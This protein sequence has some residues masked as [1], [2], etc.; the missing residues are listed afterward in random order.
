M[1]MVN[2]R[3][4]S[5]RLVSVHFLAWGPL[6]FSL[7]LPITSRCQR[8]GESFQG[9]GPSLKT[10]SKID[11]TLGWVDY[12]LAYEFGFVTVLIGDD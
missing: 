12:E 11:G 4:Y 5:S 3:V 9:E 2:A 7:N 1:H 8:F 6:K 10:G